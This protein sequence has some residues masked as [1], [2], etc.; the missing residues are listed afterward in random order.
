METAGPPPDRIRQ[1]LTDWHT[2]EGTML[3]VTYGSLIAVLS[4]AFYFVTRWLPGHTPDSLAVHVLAA[5][6][7]LVLVLAVALSRPL[8]AYAY[9]LQVI[10]IGVFLAALLVTV[11]NSGN[12][13]WYVTI[14]IVGLFGVQYAFLR[15]KDLVLIYAGALA[16][17]IVYSLVHAGFGN[18]HNL[19][20]ITLV[21]FACAF[22][23][24]SG[25]LRI[26]SQIADVELRTRLEIQTEELR[27]QSQRV[28]NLAYSDNLTGLANRAGMNDRID[29]ALDFAA[30]HD[31]MA[32]LLYLDLDG[33]KQIND[34]H[35][36]DI[37]DIVLL[38]AALRIQYVLRYGE[39][40]GRI[41]GDEFVVLIPA[42]ESPEDA[43]AVVRRI[44]DVLR[45][46]FS[47]GD[48]H[49]TL[50]ASIGTALFPQDG[51]TRLELLAHADKAMYRV[52]SERRRQP[53][54]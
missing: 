54:K 34:M 23:V 20:G 43:I 24:A 32:A 36:H 2:R 33:F 18:H 30:Q 11:V 37:G 28:R 29:R 13:L 5:A 40:I 47:V 45:E 53:V 15:R 16:F 50:S 31:L 52:K 21:G 8:R 51:T 4:P 42:I 6:V 27:R 39:S 10:N 48:T 25:L 38:G 7:S 19:F 17:E 9:R 46:R 41:G 3:L 14:T 35:G 44:R 12:S 22:S 49:F 1:A 26:R